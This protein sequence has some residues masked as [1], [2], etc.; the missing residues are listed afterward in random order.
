MSLSRTHEGRVAELVDAYASGAYG[1]TCGGSSPPSATMSTGQTR[2]EHSLS[3]REEG[4]NLHRGTLE[5]TSTVVF[6]LIET[7]SEAHD[8]TKV[9]I[10]C[11]ALCQYKR[12]Q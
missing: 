2:L 1:E 7:K 8:L 5:R 11:F 12:W 4:S 6:I 3:T 10:G 9:G